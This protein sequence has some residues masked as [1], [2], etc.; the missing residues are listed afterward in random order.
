[1]IL[2]APYAQKLRNGLPSNPKNWPQHYWTHLIKLLEKTGET[3]VQVGQE[4]EIKLVDHFMTDLR[5]NELNLLIDDCRTW[6]SVDSFLQHQA[7]NKG[8]YGVVIWGQSDPRIFGHPENTNLLKSR[9]YL[10][11]K[12]YFLWEQ[13]EYRSDVFVEPDVVYDALIDKSRSIQDPQVHLK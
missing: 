9:D 8:K 11:E 3:L 10:R 5:I 13:C 2:L 12:Q 6:V 4:G 7:W 1:M